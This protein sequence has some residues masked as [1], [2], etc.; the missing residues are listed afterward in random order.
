MTVEE[1]LQIAKAKS[2]ARSR[3]YRERQGKKKQITTAKAKS[4]ANSRKYRERQQNKQKRE[5]ACI[6][7]HG[8]DDT[9]DLSKYSTNTLSPCIHYRLVTFLHQGSFFCRGCFLRYQH[10]W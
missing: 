1:K 6:W 2:A 3:N 5:T 8:A 10:G 9:G 7:D 4:A